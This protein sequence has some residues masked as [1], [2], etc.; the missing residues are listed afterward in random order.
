MLRSILA[1]ALLLLTGPSLAQDVSIPARV[2]DEEGAPIAGAEV[3]LSCQAVRTDFGDHDLLWNGVTGDDGSVTIVVPAEWVE[4]RAVYRTLTVAAYSAGRKL[5]SFGWSPSALPVG[6]DVTIRL[7][8]LETDSSVRIV[9]ADGAAI[10]GARVFPVYFRDSDSSLTALSDETWS[11]WGVETDDEGRARLPVELANVRI[12]GV[13]GEGIGLQSFQVDEMEGPFDLQV[14]PLVER[15]FAFEGER[16]VGLGFRQDTWMQVELPTGQPVYRRYSA[17]GVVEA[18]PDQTILAPPG[19]V[20]IQ[21]VSD[22]LAAFRFAVDYGN[23]GASDDDAPFRIV[24]ADP[25][26]IVRGRVVSDETGD[27][28]PGAVVH[29]SA[30]NFGRLRTDEEGRFEASLPRRAGWV[31]VTS[32]EPP[33]GFFPGSSPDVNGQL[34]GNDEVT[35]EDVRLRRAW[36]VTGRAVLSDGR[37]ASSAWIVATQQIST[38]QMFSRTEHATTIADEEGVFELT[39]LTAGAAA[40][41]VATLDGATARAEIS[42]STEPLVLT[43]EAGLAATG[44]VRGK[45]GEPVAGLEL[46]VFSASREGVVG[47]EKL[48]SLG[49]AESF[50]SDE[51]GHFASRVG[52]EPDAR[53]SL[54]WGGRAA[55]SARSEWFTGAELA[56]GVEL[57]VVARR[58]VRGTLNGPDGKPLADARVVVRATGESVTSDASGAFALDAVAECGELVLVAT[59]DGRAS[60]GVVEPSGEAVDWTLRAPALSALDRPRDDQA[61]RAVAR[62]L[63]AERLDGELAKGDDGRALRAVRLYAWADPSDAMDRV[64]K[65]MFEVSWQR[66]FSLSYVTDALLEASPE[67]ALAVA[68]RID[69]GMSQALQVLSAAERLPPET[70]LE[71]L[72]LLRAKARAIDPPEHRVVVMARLGGRLLDLRM[73]DA[74]AAVLDEAKEVAARLPNEEWPAYARSVLGETLSRVDAEAGRALIDSMSEADNIPRH[75]G[76]TATLIA[77]DDPAAA[78]SLLDE[79]SGTRGSWSPQRYAPRVVYA[80]APVDLERA[81]AIASVHDSTGF[82]DGMIALSLLDG[83]GSR[84]EARVSLERAFERIENAPPERVR[85]QRVPTAAALLPIAARLDPLELEAWIAR[86]LALRLPEGWGGYQSDDG[87]LKGDGAIAWFVADL[88][89]A[90]ARALVVPALDAAAGRNG[91]TSRE[92]RI[93]WAAAAVLDP[94]A[95]AL[96]ARAEGGDAMDIV[97]QVLAMPT[98]ARDRYVYTSL[99]DLSLP[100]DTE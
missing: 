69:R 64:E 22:D 66:D 73:S 3:A 7:E 56:A 79:M 97:G 74:A 57:D 18:D 61:E 23:F 54:L 10:V 31:S 11:R 91:Y 33:E 21:F 98:A 8:P 15:G 77:A 84:E 48:A 37:P 43:L 17:S 49:G 28:V 13:S 72:A 89:P 9:D 51:D 27:P 60:W 75:L 81:R 16:P 99:L 71:Q 53:Y 62:D 58:A 45:D 59:A 67:E 95:T 80:M 83:S 32:V 96:R 12:I 30:S 93:V 92:I 70:E 35:L 20:R 4:R 44:L 55:T 25:T 6:H 41:L 29:L 94:E 38:N 90:L 34:E 1:L 52:L 5:E 68:H 42:E 78:E 63:L 40:K 39:G 100:G 14:T 24:P 47:G 76:N 86:V 46:R 19:L 87:R 82:S 85:D 26:T 2:V 65:G 88:D 50:R 36:T